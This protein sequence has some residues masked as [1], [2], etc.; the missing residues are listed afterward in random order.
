MFQRGLLQEMDYLGYIVS[1]GKITVSTKKVE[2][3]GEW[4]VSTTQIDVRSFEQFCNFYAKFINRFSDLTAP[5]MDLL[6]K[7]QP[8][9]VTMT[10]ACLEAFGTLMIRLIAATCLIL[11]KVSS[12]AMFNVA[13]DSSTLG[14][15]TVMLQDQGRGLQQSLNGRA[16]CQTESSLA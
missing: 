7:S 12:D 5:F 3:V 9:K 4:P 2:A 8:Q 10:S 1:T 15:A 14:I 16:S 13:T 11:P 6:R